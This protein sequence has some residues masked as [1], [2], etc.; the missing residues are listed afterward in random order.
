MA[1]GLVIHISS[2]DDKHTEV[3]TN[4]RIRIGNCDDCDLRLRLSSLPK[5]P[6]N[7]GILLEL[8]RTNGFYKI[9]DFDRSLVLTYNG[10]PLERDTEINDGD[11]VRIDQ[12]NL[13][14]QFFPI[15]SLPAVVSGSARETHVAPFIEAAAIESAATARRDDAKVFLR[16]FTRE[17]VREIN[18]ST[19]LITLGMALLLVGGVLYI[20]Y[21]MYKELERSR[22]LIDDQR[23]QMGLMKDQVSKTND[24]LSDLGRSNKEIRDSLSLAVKLRS[25]YGRGVCLIA[26]SFYFV[27]PGT[28]G[29][30]RYPEAQTSET[31][32][33]VQGS[34]D[35]ANLSPEGHAAIAEYEFV[36]TG[37]YVGNGFV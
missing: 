12:S 36:G 37:F 28:G 3:L 15:R 20:G 24:Q 18:P 16:E 33:N 21:A 32:A 14:L 9:T 17:L 8:E 6:E 2:G 26:G 11:E 1:T 4:E 10:E 30:L 5:R 34:N 29:A 27:E 25:D 19:K 23:A 31:G 13:A 35:P 7:D 22:R